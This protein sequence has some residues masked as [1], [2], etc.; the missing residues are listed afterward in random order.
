MKARYIFKRGIKIESVAGINQN[1]AWGQDS[2]ADF[3]MSLKVLYPK[4]EIVSEQFPKIFAGQYG[5]EVSA[6]SLAKPDLIHSS[7][8]GSD[9]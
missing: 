7:F 6:L 2:W 5:A 3:T 8:W 1:Y 4:I 9:L